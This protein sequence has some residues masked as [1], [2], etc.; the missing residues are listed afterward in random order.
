M[1]HSNTKGNKK[2]LKGRYTTHV[3]K[4]ERLVSAEFQLTFRGHEHLSVLVRT[5]QIPEMTREDVEDYGPNGIKFNQHGP[6]RNSGELQVQCVETIE[7]DILKFIKERIA[8]K[9]YVDIEMAA[10]PESKATSVDVPTNPLTTIEMLDCKIYSDAID[11]S[12]EDVTAAVRPPLRIVYNWI[13]W[14]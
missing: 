4:G 12:T 5:A 14:D 10:T 13:D 1:G 11:M 2:F 8:A 6:I 7:G 9:D 3:A